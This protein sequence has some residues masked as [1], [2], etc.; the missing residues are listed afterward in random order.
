[1]ATIKLSSLKNN[2]KNPR[3]I[4]DDDFQKLKDSIVQFPKMMELRPIVVDDKNMILAG[5]QKRAALLDL[6]HK[7]IPTNWVKKAKDLTDEEKERFIVQDNHHAGGWDFGILA[8]Q[9]DMPKLAGWGIDLS[10]P[11]ETTPVS[12]S[13]SKRVKETQVRVQCKTTKEAS[14]LFTKLLA[15]GFECEIK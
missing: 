8:T 10:A 1:M 13:A 6:G 15:D 2:P 5:H 12:F 11:K 4:K 7:E 3:V 14:D 9:Y